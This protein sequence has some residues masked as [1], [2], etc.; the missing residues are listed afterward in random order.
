MK[1][2]EKLQEFKQQC[3][4]LRLIEEEMKPG[5]D[6]FEYDALQYTDLLVVERE[7]QLLTEIWELKDEW[8]ENWKSWKDLGFYD[9]RIEDMD[10]VAVE[11]TQ[12]LM[13]MNKEAR[14]WPIYEF[15]KLKFAKFRDTMP[16]ITD[17]RDESIRPRHWNDIRFE[18][19]EEFNE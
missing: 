17:L 4:E 14:Q 6:I 13:N 19:K 7:N 5:L 11:F 3:V 16:L 1:S 15:L 18:V 8:D 2:L 10:E 12:R 9:L